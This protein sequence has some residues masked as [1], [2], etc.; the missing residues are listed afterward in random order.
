[1]LREWNSC[2][3]LEEKITGQRSIV[4]RPRQASRQPS[5]PVVQCP[6]RLVSKDGQNDQIIEEV[7]QEKK[8]L[9]RH[10]F[11]GDDNFG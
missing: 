10:G 9:G 4:G 5:M 2:R 11:S 7:G 6:H 8:K 3:L 1:M